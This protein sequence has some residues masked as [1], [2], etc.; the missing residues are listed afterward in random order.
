MFEPGTILKYFPPSSQLKH[1]YKMLHN[2]CLDSIFPRKGS[3]NKVT[4]IDMMMMYHMFNKVKINLPYV[5]IQHMIHT[6]EIA[7]KKISLPYGMFLT[8]VFRHFRVNLSGEDGKNSSTTFTMTNI[9]RMKQVSEIEDHTVNDQGLKRKREA[10]DNTEPENL[11]LLADVVTTEEDHLENILPIPSASD[12]GKQI[13]SEGNPSDSRDLG[14]S[15]EFDSAFEDNLGPNV[16]KFTY[17]LLD[18]FSTIDN[19]V[20]TSLFSPLITTPQTTFDSYQQAEMLKNLMKNPIPNFPQFSQFSHFPTPIFND[21]G[22]SL[23]SFPQHF[24]SL[25]SFCTN[26]PHH[27][28]AAYPHSDNPPPFDPRPQKKSKLEKDMGRTRK[29]MEKMFNILTYF[30]QEQQIFR[31]WLAEEFCPAMRIPPPP[32]NPAP[33]AEEIPKFSSSS[34]DSS[35]TLPQ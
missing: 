23:P 12:K 22:P 3:K 35:P 24:A 18:G 1:E 20:N 7:T 14:I 16:N 6:I 33:P 30:M 32:A 21:A 19:P 15:L 9:G 2:M 25:G 31:T 4:D 26:A 27:D 8:R 34:D 28:T 10:F 17:V 11:R 5:L 13:M 29:D